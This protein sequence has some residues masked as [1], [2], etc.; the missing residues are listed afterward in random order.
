MPTKQPD[1]IALLKEDHRKVEGLFE[2]FEKTRD[3]ARKTPIVKDIC[4]ELIIHCLIEEELFYPTFRGRVEDELLD[5]AHVEHDGAKMLIAELLEAHVEHD[6]AKMLIAELLES[7]PGAPF[8]DA[9]VSVLS[10]EIKHHVKE[11]ERPGKGLFAQARATGEDLNMLGERMRSRKEEL[12]A[13]F[14]AKGL[15]TPVSR[16]LVGAQ[17]KHGE[18][19]G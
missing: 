4:T 16:S 5:E 10:E 3:D 15:P 1:A 2:R 19:V 12:K 14:A 11:E 17:L 8:Y 7:E 18:P 6:G 13:Q 9:K